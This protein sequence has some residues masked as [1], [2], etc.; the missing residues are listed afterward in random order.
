MLAANEI[1]IKISLSSAD[2]D[3][4]GTESQIMTMIFFTF[5]FFNVF[6]ISIL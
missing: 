1:I 2:C 6:F 5:F 4:N 3:N